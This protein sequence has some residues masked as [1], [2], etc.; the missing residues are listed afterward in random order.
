MTPAA[1]PGSFPFPSHHTRA[2]VSI[3]HIVEDGRLAVKLPERTQSGGPVW[4]EW[5]Q[6][7]PAIDPHCS[8][9]QE[10]GQGP[11][12]SRL[13]GQVDEYGLQ[14]A[15]TAGAHCDWGSGGGGLPTMNICKGGGG[16]VVRGMAAAGGKGH[17][18]SRW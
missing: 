12:C 10:W 15:G 14:A 16:Q 6:A 4:Q 5:G 3:V 18:G 17:G 1:I 13:A 11:P 7:R 2:V 9:G 8:T